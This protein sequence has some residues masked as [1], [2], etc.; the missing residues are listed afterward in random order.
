M[1]LGDITYHAIFSIPSYTIFLEKT[2]PSQQTS[3]KT[4]LFARDATP[5]NP[6]CEKTKKERILMCFDA[7]EDP[8]FKILFD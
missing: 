3:F 1:L 5:Q 8:C 7:Y 4:V 2:I 6:T